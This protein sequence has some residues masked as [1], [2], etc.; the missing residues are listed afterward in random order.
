MHELPENLTNSLRSFRG[1]IYGN[2]KTSGQ[3]ERDG[4]DLEKGAEEY[5]DDDFNKA[6]DTSE[7]SV[8]LVIRPC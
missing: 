6:L 2:R 4:D 8:R 5:H 1:S 7:N 3:Q